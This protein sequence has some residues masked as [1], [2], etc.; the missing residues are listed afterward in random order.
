MPM[1]PSHAFGAAARYRFEKPAHL[2]LTPVYGR[3]AGN[4]QQER[5]SYSFPLR[6]G[7]WETQLEKVVGMGLLMSLFRWWSIL[8]PSPPPLTA[9]E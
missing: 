5:M 9:E 1:C 8:G 2:E 4:I 7:R 6:E 3:P